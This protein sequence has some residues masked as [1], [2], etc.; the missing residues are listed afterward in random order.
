MKILAYGKNTYT[1]VKRMFTCMRCGCIFVADYDE[2]EAKDDFR[3]GTFYQSGC[4]CCHATA[5]ADENSIYVSTE[6]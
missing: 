6:D 2:Y 3:N 4:P 1:K 5:Y